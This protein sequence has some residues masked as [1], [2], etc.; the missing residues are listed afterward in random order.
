MQLCG[1]DNQEDSSMSKS[2]KYY[3]LRSFFSY[4]R[5]FKV[6]LVTIW[7]GF[8]TANVL[9]AIM[10]IFIGKLVG[11]LA[12]SPIQSHHA[13]IYAWILIA[14]SVLHSIAW[15]GSELFYMKFINPL[16]YMYENNLFRQVINKPYPYF[17]D[18]FTGKVSSYISTIT[19]EVKGF[20]DNIYYNYTGSI[21]SIIVIAGILTSINWQTG[22][23]FAFAIFSMI[24]VGR[25][26]IRNSSKYE[27]VFA[28]VQSTKSGKLVDVVANFVNVKSFQKE[29]VE[30]ESIRIQQVNTVVAARKSFIWAVYFWATMSFFV[31]SVIW[32][33]TIGL[34]VYLFLHHEISIA[35][36]ATL[37]ST[38]L[39]FSSSIWDLIWHLS[40]FNLKLARIEEA[41]IYLFG[42]VNIVKQYQGELIA[43]PI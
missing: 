3:S 1:T 38:V 39:L 21:I 5:A 19:Q 20:L 30:I 17:V 7:L 35:Q 2:I 18:K 13:A 12:A 42:K 25:H 32:P 37:L 43:P 15:H 31:R 6:R 9:L 24:L 26:T 28:D 8:V 27:K 22:A 29:A 40:Q 4:L 36:L 41:H 23:I 10:P 16:G 11:A 34:N 33:A 14:C